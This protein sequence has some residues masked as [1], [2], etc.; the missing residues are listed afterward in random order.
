MKVL[1]TGITGQD[2]SYLAEFLLQKDYEV[3]GL[4]RRASTFNTERIEHIY[5]DPHDPDAKLFL[6]YGDLS[7]SNQLTNLIYNIQPDEIYHLGAQSHVRVS[8]DMPEYTGDIVGLGTTRILEAMRRSGVK[9]RYY[10]ASSSEM[11]GSAPPPQNEDTPFQP[12]SPYAAAKVYAYHMVKNYRDGYGMFACNGILFN[13]ESPRRGETFVTRKITRALARI[14]YGLQECLYLGNLEARRDWGYA[15]DFVE[16]MWLML[17]QDKPDDFVA[18][19]GQSH[20]VRNFC[21][22]AFREMGIDIEW[23]GSGINE[24]GIIAAYNNTLQL[25][26]GNCQLATGTTVVAVDPRYFRPT[27]VDFLLGDPSK[28]RKILGWEPKVKFSELVKIMVQADIQD[29]L[30]LQRAQDVIYRI[31]NG[32]VKNEASIG[33]RIKTGMLE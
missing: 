17:Q 21:E 29:L 15:P 12:Q 13:H 24:V 28:A 9:A 16:A 25:P 3:H 26:A 6:H 18:A 4:V 30:N 32:E 11:F 14:R 7:D 8:F 10:Q 27:E 1:I 19:T 20:S 31:I 2:G 23:R 5:Q 22:L 33:N